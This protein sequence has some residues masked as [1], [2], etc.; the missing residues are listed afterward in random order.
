MTIVS[1][2]PFTLTNGTTADASQVQADLDQIRDDVNTNV[3]IEITTA[4]EEAVIASTDNTYI[5]LNPQSA[6]YITVPTDAGKMIVHPSADV[7]GRTFTIASNALVPYL[8]GTVISF[9]NQHS[10]GTLTIAIAGGDTL[11]LCGAGS[12]G[13]RTLAADGVA[14]AIKEGTNSWFILGTG[15]T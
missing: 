10:A 5:P 2:L 14:T 1:P 13:S 7:T 4:V 15:L 9:W 6:A 3:P 12:T 11:R 8:L